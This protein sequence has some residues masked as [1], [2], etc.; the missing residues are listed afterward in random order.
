MLEY[1]LTRGPKATG[2]DRDSGCGFRGPGETRVESDKRVIKE[3][4]LLVKREIAKVQHQRS[5]HR[6]SRDRLGIPAIALV[7]YTNA[8][9]STLMNRLSQ[10][11]VLA[12]DMLFATLDP[13]TRKV[14]LPRIS[15]SGGS[16][17]SEDSVTVKGN[18]VE[19]VLFLF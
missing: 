2:T 5:Q 9:K 7:G 13:T 19:C 8:G 10:A 6:R 11:G 18:T 4:I 14:Q 3:R 17:N 15:S 16:G 1:R 12:E